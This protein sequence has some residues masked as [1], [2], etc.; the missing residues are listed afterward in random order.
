MPTIIYNS[1]RKNDRPQDPI[2]QLKIPMVAQK[3]C[4]K[5]WQFGRA[6]SKRFAGPDKGKYSLYIL[7]SIQ[8]TNINSAGKTWNFFMLNLGV[9]KVTF[10]SFSCMALQLSIQFWP[11]QPTFLSILFY[12]SFIHSFIYFHSI[13]PYKVIDNLQDIEHVILLMLSRYRKSI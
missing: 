10:F 12:L 2:L 11:S 3:H 4:S 13:N 7:R 6:L 5:N 9:C 8:S 1:N